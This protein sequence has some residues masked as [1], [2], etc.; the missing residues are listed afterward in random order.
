MS[1]ENDCTSSQLFHLALHV[2]VSDCFFVGFRRP[3]LL[4]F[5]FTTPTVPRWMLLRKMS[6]CPPLDPF[7][8]TSLDF[9]VKMDLIKYLV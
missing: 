9:H 8:E 3:T 6:R 7:E 4:L 1:V 2:R 5:T